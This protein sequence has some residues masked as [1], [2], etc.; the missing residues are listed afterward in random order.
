MPA[1]PAVAKDSAGVEAVESQCHE[2]AKKK[3]PENSQQHRLIHQQC[4][5]PPTEAGDLWRPI[6]F[7]NF[8]VHGR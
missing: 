8:V 5:R 2:G 7:G 6:A 4:Q 3:D 1:T